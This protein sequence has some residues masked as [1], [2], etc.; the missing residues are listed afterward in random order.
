MVTY[1]VPVRCE[2]SYNALCDWSNRVDVRSEIKSPFSFARA[3]RKKTA[4]DS[5]PGTQRIKVMSQNGGLK[6]WNLN[7][8]KV[9]WP[10]PN[11]TFLKSR[12][13]FWQIVHRYGLMH[14]GGAF[15][16]MD[17]TV[18]RLLSASQFWIRC[19]ST[20]RH[21]YWVANLLVPC[22]VL[23]SY[24]VSCGIHL[25][26]QHSR[27]RASALFRPTR[28]PGTRYILTDTPWYPVPRIP[29]H[30]VA[31]QTAKE[32]AR[33]DLAFTL[34]EV[35]LHHQTSFTY[36]TDRTKVLEVDPKYKRLGFRSSEQWDDGARREPNPYRYW[37]LRKTS[38]WSR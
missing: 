37:Q 7:F 9:E 20:H 21:V 1:W 12:A 32:R 38:S 17:H 2:T 3:L 30:Q 35:Y 19:V 24:R 26:F 25:L 14:L 28:A 33:G 8:A 22:I 15:C 5:S 4:R 36:Y 11:T 10:G 29:P 23:L 13:F 18:H 34:Q 16:H 6:P 27:V 31:S